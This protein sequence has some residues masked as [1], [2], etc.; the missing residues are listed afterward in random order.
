MKRLWNI[1]VCFSIVLPAFGQQ[2]PIFSLYRENSFVLNPA[3]T[4]SEGTGI[5][6]FTY[7]DQWSEIEESPRTVSAGYRMPIYY[8]KDRFQRAGNFIGVGGHLVNDK[9]GPTAYTQLSLTYAYHISFAKINPFHWARFLR[10]SHISLGLSLGLNQ[11]RLNASELIPDQP[12][13]QLVASADRSKFL[14][15]AGLGVYYYYDN[16]YLGFSS[17][18]IIPL[19][20]KFESNDGISTLQ[21]EN[22]FFL[23]AGGKI[24]MGGK[25]PRGYEHKFYIE[26]MV[27]LKYVK[28]APYQADAYFRFRHKN[29]AWAGLGYRTSK[30]IIIDAGFMIKKALKIGYAYDLQVSRLS[31][32][33]GNT[34]EIL[35]SYHF[36]SDTRRRY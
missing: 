8:Q 13:D 7:R 15:N 34:H 2:L 25:V 11:H 21:R 22:H 30:T 23:V 36:S 16:F 32:Y 3:I 26:P 4:G 31:S 35:L 10:K 6:A 14:P 29:L 19:K 17:P 1:L 18:Q 12:N 24:P 28:D 33:L 20:V 27:W 9:T 5:L